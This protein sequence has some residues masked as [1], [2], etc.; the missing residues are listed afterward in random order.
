MRRTN[1]LQMLMLGVS[2]AMVSLMCVRLLGWSTTLA[3]LGVVALFLILGWL[4]S[5]G[6][7]LASRLAVF[8]LTR[9]LIRLVCRVAGLPMPAPPLTTTRPSAGGP[10][11]R[12]AAEF[13]T[14]CRQLKQQILGHDAAIDA[15]VT[16]LRQSLTLRAN[17]AS[18]TAGPLAVI[19]LAGNNGLGKRTTLE[20]VG[21]AVYPTG[22]VLILDLAAVSD[23]IGDWVQAVAAEP[24]LA[25]VLENIDTADAKM[26]DRIRR[27]IVTGELLHDDR[28]RQSISA[29]IIGLTMTDPEALKRG[30][31]AFQSA[32]GV[33]IPFLPPTPETLVRVTE[34]LMQSECQRYGLTLDHVDERL[35]AGMASQFDMTHGYPLV[36][37]ALR[38]RFAP[39]IVLAI[40]HRQDHLAILEEIL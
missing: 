33:P 8:P 29:N 22:R 14:L 7:P 20:L 35:V 9:P 37:A 32:F 17:V 11:V 4:I 30:G 19:L 3:L 39:D 38:E 1:G 24:S 21:R 40:E 31:A 27:A 5:V 34:R 16:K 28:T 18:G 10:A 6:H 25:V 12:T 15:I 2:L 13:D 36:A 23:P 26:L